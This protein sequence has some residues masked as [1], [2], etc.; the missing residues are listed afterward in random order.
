LWHEIQWTWLLW[1]LHHALG[2]LLGDALRSLVTARTGAAPA[3]V[4][5]LLRAGG[6]LYVWVW[7]ALSQCFTLISDPA[8]AL[9]A[10]LG[11]LTPWG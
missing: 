3:A 7:L 9:A 8:L 11:M 5:V 4:G 6:V 1:G 2:I 10:Y